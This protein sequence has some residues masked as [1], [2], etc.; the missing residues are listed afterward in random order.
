MKSGKKNMEKEK[1]LHR[2]VLLFDI[3]IEVVNKS[4]INN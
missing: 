4:I 1:D 2:T 3:M